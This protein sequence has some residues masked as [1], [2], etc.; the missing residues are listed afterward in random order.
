MIENFYQKIFNQ[1]IGDFCNFFLYQDSNWSST[2]DIF[3][4]LLRDYLFIYSYFL[5]FVGEYLC[6]LIT[7]ITKSIYILLY[8][9]VTNILRHLA[10]TCARSE[11]KGTAQRQYGNADLTSG[12]AYKKGLTKITG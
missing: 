5:I 2:L 9:Q 7:F 6:V 8:I 10:F 12:S 11:P 3:C 1:L 4:Y